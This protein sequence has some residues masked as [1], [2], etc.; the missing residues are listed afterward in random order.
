MSIESSFEIAWRAKAMATA[1]QKAIDT[2][3]AQW[4]SSDDSDL[5]YCYSEVERDLKKKLQFL[6]EQLNEN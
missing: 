2:L 5:D 1:V 6:Q 3:N 4:P